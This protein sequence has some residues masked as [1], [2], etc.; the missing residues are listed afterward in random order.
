MKLS[1]QAKRMSLENVES[2]KWTRRRM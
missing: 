2:S 1:F